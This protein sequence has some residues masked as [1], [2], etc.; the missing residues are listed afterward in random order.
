MSLRGALSRP[1]TITG[2]RLVY[3]YLIPMLAIGWGL[4]GYM[5]NTEELRKG[6]VV[7]AERVHRIVCERQATNAEA[8][9][10]QNRRQLKQNERL[11]RLLDAALASRRAAGQANGFEH[12]AL[13]VIAAMRQERREIGVENA[14]LRPAATADCAKLPSAA[15]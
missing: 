9:I 13:T 1:V 11:K 10:S 14:E 2:S 3:G 4:G 6:R 12:E 15:P 7:D 8:N 5:W